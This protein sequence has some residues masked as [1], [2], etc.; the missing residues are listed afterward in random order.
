MTFATFLKEQQ[1]R[2]FAQPWPVISSA[3]VIGALNVFLFAFD[4]PWTASDGLRNWGDVLLHLTRIN[5]H[6]DLLSPL[7]YSG[8]VLNLGVLFGS[9]AAALLSREFAIRPAPALELVKG[10]FGGLLMGTGAML[11][12]GCNI[13]GFFSALSALSLSGAAMM[14]GLVLGSFVAARYLVWE[15]RRRMEAGQLPF[16]SACAA[17][18]PPPA[19]SAAFK[20]QPLCGALAVLVLAGAGVFYQRFGHARLAAF[21]FF[22][23]AIGFVLQR[24][25]FCLVNAFREP[26]MSGVSEHGRAAALALILSAVGFAILKATDLKD[27]TE[28]VFPSFWWGS[29]SGGILFGG[30][31]VLAGG[32]GAGSIWRAGEGQIK[33]WV[34]VVFFALGASVSRRFLVETELIHRLGLPVF[35]PNVLGWAGALSSFV[36]LMIL[37][38]LLTAWNEERR[39][40]GVLKM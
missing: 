6:S 25:R 40:A 2:I 11:A 38:Y 4:R 21:L 15:N 3:L 17:P 32:C 29:L 19:D 16:V 37:W 24:S 10:G 18:A 30:G 13:G 5:D 27:T 12:F 35:L 39:R 7:L 34:A 36:L 22:G 9:L 14:G 20:A 23:A 26:F 8:S 28:W 31:M 33:L 1:G